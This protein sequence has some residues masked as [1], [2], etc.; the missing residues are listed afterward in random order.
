MILDAPDLRV[1]IV[2][3]HEVVRDGIRAR[4]GSSRFRIVGECHTVADALREID[5]LRPDIVITE[6]RLPDGEGLELAA[7]RAN[8]PNLRVLLLSAHLSPT[9]I[10]RALEQG[11]QGFVCKGTGAETI[12]MAINAVADDQCYV[13]APLVSGLLQ[14]RGARQLTARERDVLNAMAKGMA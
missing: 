13:D 9:V 14:L 5:A 4:L 8:H 11:V 6:H 3:D 10:E 2:D 7:A 1:L 12:L